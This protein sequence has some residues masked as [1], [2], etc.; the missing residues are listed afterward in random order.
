[1]WDNTVAKPIL[2]METNA[3]L[4]F[5]LGL[6]PH[7]LIMSMLGGHGGRLE[8]GREIHTL[9]LGLCLPKAWKSG[10]N[11]QNPTLKNV[12]PVIKIY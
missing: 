2:G 6:E 1:M 3:T 12:F 11:P 4:D 8:I 9:L 7:H 10:Q 5:A